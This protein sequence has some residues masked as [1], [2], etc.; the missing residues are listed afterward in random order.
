MAV[1]ATAD[2]RVRHEV[3]LAATRKRPDLRRK[4][5]SRQGPDAPGAFL[6]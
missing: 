2:Y 3:A 4:S 1:S 6:A 5:H